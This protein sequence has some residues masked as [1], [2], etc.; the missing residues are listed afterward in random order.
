MWAVRELGQDLVGRTGTE[1]DVEQQFA[2]PWVLAA[3]TEIA[4][5]QACAFVAWLRETEA[6]GHCSDP[7]VKFGDRKRTIVQPAE[8]GDQPRVHPR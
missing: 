5:Q 7:A 6:L 8:C 3:C 1:G 2:D 4:H